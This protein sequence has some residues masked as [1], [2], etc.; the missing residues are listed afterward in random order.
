MNVI[1]YDEIFENFYTFG[2]SDLKEIILFTQS[3]RC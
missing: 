3:T 2:G 1:D